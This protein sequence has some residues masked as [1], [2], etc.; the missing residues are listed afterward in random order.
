LKQIGVI[1]YG[2]DDSPVVPLL[3]YMFSKIGYVPTESPSAFMS[4]YYYYYFV[5]RIGVGFLTG[6]E[7]LLLIT[8]RLAL[9]S[10]QPPVQASRDACCMLELLFDPEAVCSSEM[11]VTPTR[12]H[13]V[14]SHNTAVYRNI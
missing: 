3:V 14:K 4:S 1:L 2:N 13:S 8:S 6:A 7:I 11:P 9:A 5:S 12:L 10:I